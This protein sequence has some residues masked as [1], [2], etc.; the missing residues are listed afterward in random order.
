MITCLPLDGWP[1]ADRLGWLRACESGV[2]WRRGG[3][4]SRWK[5]ITKEDLERRYGYFLEPLRERGALDPQAGA[6]RL[7]TPENVD[8][9]IERVRSGWTSVTLGHSV[10]K[11]RRMAG[12]LALLG[13]RLADCNC[14]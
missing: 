9:Y 1:A 2:R 11:L 12:I 5:L 8:C 7:V 6:G 10:Y 4:A 3:A 13:P 14:Q